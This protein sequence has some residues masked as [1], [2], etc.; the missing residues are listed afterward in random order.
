MT[1]TE[2]ETDTKYQVTD[3]LEITEILEPS[4]RI[5]VRHPKRSEMIKIVRTNPRFIFY[6]ILYE[7]GKSIPELDGTYTTAKQ[8]LDDLKGYLARAKP[9]TQAKA[10]QRHGDKPIPELKRKKVPTNV[11]SVEANQNNS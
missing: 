7:T 6:K 8:A 9:T 4:H 5:E 11:N 3:E 10:K 2:M 1:D